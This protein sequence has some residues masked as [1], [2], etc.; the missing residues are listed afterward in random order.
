MRALF[1]LP[2]VFACASADGPVT[3]ES[4]AVSDF[5]AASDQCGA[6]S[7]CLD[8]AESD[9]LD[10]LDACDAMTARKR[11]GRMG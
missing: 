9:H 8:E 2:F 11:P 7:A 6:D 4:L 5:D 3:C 1:L 10:A